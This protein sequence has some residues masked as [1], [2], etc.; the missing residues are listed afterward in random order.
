[1]IF[2]YCVGASVPRRFGKVKQGLTLGNLRQSLWE[3]SGP[4]YGQ[5][6]GASKG[7]LVNL[8]VLSFTCE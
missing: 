3:A 5:K 2:F 1:M 4:D 8:I 6:K 7:P